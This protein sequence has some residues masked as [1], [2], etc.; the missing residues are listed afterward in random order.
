[1]GVKL[2]NFEVEDSKIGEYF[3]S[4]VL[5]NRLTNFRWELVSVYGLAQ[6]EATAE[7]ISNLSRKCLYTTLPIL[8]GV[9]GGGGL[10]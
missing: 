3:V 5:R 7:F 8:L 6:H 1:L 10:T 4:M 9:G 2:D